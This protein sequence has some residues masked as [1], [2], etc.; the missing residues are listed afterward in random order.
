MQQVRGD[1][2]EPC[3]ALTGSTFPGVPHDAEHFN[4]V[5]LFYFL[6]RFIMANT[7]SVVSGSAAT[8]SS[9]SDIYQAMAE[10]NEIN[11]ANTLAKL[12]TMG[13]KAAKDIVG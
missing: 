8:S 1:A 13:L 4:A 9:I 11:K 7:S 10:E 5:P 12:A 6:R 3:A 2:G